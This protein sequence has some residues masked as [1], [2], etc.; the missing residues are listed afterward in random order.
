MKVLFI[1]DWDYTLLWHPIAKKLKSS[2]FADECVALVVGKIYYDK[3]CTENDGVYDHIY[4]MQEGTEH[5]PDHLPDIDVKLSTIQERYSESLLWRFVWADRSWVK[6]GY[7]E[8]RKRLVVCFDYFEKLF[9]EEKPDLVLANAYA[10]MPHLIS[11][12]VAHKREI[13]VFRPMSVRLEDRYI[14]SDNAM[15]EEDWIADYFTGKNTLAPET[16]TEVGLFLKEFRKN[17]KK[18]AYQTL[19]AKEHNATFGHL[20]RF[21]RY[22]YRYWFSGIFAGEHSKPN[23]FKR[24]WDESAWRI[25][26]VFWAKPS[27]W[28]F[29][30]CNEKYV[31]FPLHV[32]PEMSTMT[33]AP[34]Y[35]DQLSILENLSKSLP[36]DY[37]LLVKEHPSMLGRRK[38][39]YYDRIKALPNIRFV[40]PLSD[41]FEITKNAAAIFTITG[42][43]GLEGMIMQKPV[44]FL[45]ST[46]YRYCPLAINA[47]NI[48]PT[49]WP[50]LLAAALNQHEHDEEVLTT[51]LG[52]VF[53]RSFSGIYVEP[54]TAPEQVLAND[55][56]DKLIEQIKLFA[57]GKL[58]AQVSRQKIHSKQA[59][60]ISG[61]GA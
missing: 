3:L 45:G 39:E 56:L 30:D 32:Q 57:V 52:A 37:R 1:C 26:R 43:V 53:E 24:L 9:S 36:I 40:S 5:V 31:Y 46:F 15:E 8:I 58:D 34:F 54:L 38:D 4:L 13:P 7:D 51:F 49:Q 16:R 59:D 29:Y 27:N 60:V 41:S 25:R 21:I 28:D 47:M 6:C 33:F 50:Q 10:S 14:M 42:T 23:P 19:R 2:G 11:Y 17:S 44:I 55:N 12:E 35:L 20:Y 61:T 48:A 22:S 18:P